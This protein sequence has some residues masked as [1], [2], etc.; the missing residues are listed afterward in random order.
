[1]MVFCGLLLGLLSS[2]AWAIRVGKLRRCKDSF[3]IE[4]RD[5]LVL[6]RS[7]KAQVVFCECKISAMLS[8]FT[9]AAMAIES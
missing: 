2:S 8:E 6:Q 5:L 9:N 1:M 7:E 4:F 3:G